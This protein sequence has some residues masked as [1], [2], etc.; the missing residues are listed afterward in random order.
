MPSISISVSVWEVVTISQQTVL[1]GWEDKPIPQRV[2]T[3]G[4]SWFLK[5]FRTWNVIS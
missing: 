5:G 4:A 2:E 3:A 1:L